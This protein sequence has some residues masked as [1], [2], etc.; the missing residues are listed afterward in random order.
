MP[1][2]EEEDCKRHNTSDKEHIRKAAHRLFQWSRPSA[3]HGPTCVPSLEIA[4]PE[5]RRIG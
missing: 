1:V 2:T 3:T 4:L 5:G